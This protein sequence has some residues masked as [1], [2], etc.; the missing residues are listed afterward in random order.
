MACSISSSAEQQLLGIEL[1]RTAAELRALQL[2]QQMPQAI[3]LR[4]RLVALR[5]RGIT[6]SACRREQRLQRFDIH[7]Q[8]RC[9]LVHARH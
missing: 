6:L 1:L 5:E 3:D 2:A 9:G 4:Q 7:R 8:L